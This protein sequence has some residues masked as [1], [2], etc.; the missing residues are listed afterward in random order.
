M[1]MPP[2]SAVT[3]T[4]PRAIELAADQITMHQQQAEHAK[5]L[6]QKHLGD[7]EAAD[8]RIAEMWQEI[9]RRQQELDQVKEQI[10]EQIMRAEAVREQAK[11][12][13]TKAATERDAH[14]Q[15]W[16][17]LAAQLNP[18][19]VR[20]VAERRPPAESPARADAFIGDA[21]RAQYPDLQPQ[22]ADGRTNGSQ[23]A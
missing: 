8:Q 10:T 3:I 18:E 7:A 23:H 22:S 21:I 5:Q 17:T 4:N 20:Q 14:Q 15:I 11:A 1:T 9:T 2:A 12:E 6:M 13:A 19:T 16:Q